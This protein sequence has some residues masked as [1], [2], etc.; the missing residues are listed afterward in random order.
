MKSEPKS[1]LT[2]KDYVNLR[3]FCGKWYEIARLPYQVTENAHCVT[4]TYEL[5]KDDKIIITEKFIIGSEKGSFTTIKSVALPTDMSN[6][7]LKV[8]L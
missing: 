6:S 4:Y 1:D 5:D 8:Q 3:R 2:T 7:K